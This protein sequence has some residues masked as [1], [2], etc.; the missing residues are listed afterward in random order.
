M[1]ILNYITPVESLTLSDQKEYRMRA[2]AAGIARAMAKDIGN[3][4]DIPSLAGQTNEMARMTT[5]LNHLKGGGEW[6]RS[7]DCREF[8]PTLDAGATNDFWETAALAARGTAYTVFNGAAA[9]TLAAN[10]EAV[11]Y[12]VGIFTTTLPVS[13]LTFRSQGG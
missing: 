7:L 9:P 2:V 6:P 11:F 3:E 13:R 1:G 8:Q 12:K 5:V 10:K 4:D